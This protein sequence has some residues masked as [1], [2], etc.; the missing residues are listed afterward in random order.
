MV[1]SGVLLFGVPLAASEQI[2]VCSNR[3][4]VLFH[5]SGVFWPVLACGCTDRCTRWNR[6]CRWAFAYKGRTIKT[7]Y[8]SQAATNGELDGEGRIG[9]RSEQEGIE[10]GTGNVGAGV[11]LLIC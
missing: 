1:A 5:I 4:F 3:I 2:G 11:R 10:L 9:Q 6:R 8:R 7:V